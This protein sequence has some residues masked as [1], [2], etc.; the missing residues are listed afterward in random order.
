MRLDV[1]S[2][3]MAVAASIAATLIVKKI[4]DKGTDPNGE[5]VVEDESEG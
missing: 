3:F 4:T 5:T 2:F 1:G